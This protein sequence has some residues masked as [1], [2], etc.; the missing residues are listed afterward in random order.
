MIIRP[1]PNLVDEIERVEAGGTPR[2]KFD[3]NANNPSGNAAEGEK[4]DA[5]RIWGVD[6]S[7][8]SI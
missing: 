8:V 5:D 3:S 4:S 7:L 2:I 1:A 6:F